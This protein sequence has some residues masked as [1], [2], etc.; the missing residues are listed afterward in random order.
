MKTLLKIITLV[1]VVGLTNISAQQAVID[2]EGIYLMCE[3]MPELVGGMD[4]I[5]KKIRY[6]LQAKS[7]GVQGVVYVQCIIDEEGKIVKP[8]VVKKLGA[9]CDEESIRVLKKSKFKPGYDKGK[10]VKVR[11]TLPIFFRL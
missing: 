2:D 10:P 3:K 1:F 9:G 7:L 4:A 5:Q 6:P 8:K 11:F